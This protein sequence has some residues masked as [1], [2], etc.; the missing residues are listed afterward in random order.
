MLII[1]SILFAILFCILGGR[2]DGSAIIALHLRTQ[3]RTSIIPF[4][5]MI[6]CIAIAPI[7][8]TKVGSTVINLLSI[9]QLKAKTS[10]IVILAATCITLCILNILCIPTS[11]T[12][13]LVGA[14][15]G[16]GFTFGDGNWS[17]V[18]KVLLIAFAAPFISFGIARAIENFCRQ[19]RIVKPNKILLF[20][21]FILVCIAYGANDGQKLSSAAS[22]AFDTNIQK[23]VVSPIIISLLISFFLAGIIFGM[24]SGIRFI[25]GGSIVPNELQI[26]ITLWASAIAVLS[27]S[28]LGTPVSMTQALS[29]ALI[30]TCPSGDWKRVRWNEVKRIAIAWCATLP[31]AWI[32]G[33]IISKSLFAT[34]LL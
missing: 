10:L 12:L 29:G 8:S 31:T 23:I 28:V 19:I 3:W 21:G 18:L 1:L 6:A 2:N 24:K 32:L 22:I 33:Y 7:L 11:I 14:S 9:H 26:N 4:V 27:S 5:I 16:V 17:S 15:S 30:G 25:Q 20:I 34:I 13:A